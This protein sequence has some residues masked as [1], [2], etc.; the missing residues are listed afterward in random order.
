M[1]NKNMIKTTPGCSIISFM[2][3]CS[4]FDLCIYT[5]SCPDPIVNICFPVDR[6]RLLSEEEL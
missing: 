2:M 6:S 1:E 5:R 4:T 3:I